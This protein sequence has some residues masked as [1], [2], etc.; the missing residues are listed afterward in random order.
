MQT[1]ILW[2]IKIIIILNDSTQGCP[3]QSSKCMAQVHKLRVLIP[4]KIWD[5]RG[6][7]RGPKGNGDGWSA[8]SYTGRM[9]SSDEG[10]G[11]KNRWPNWV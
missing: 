4:V 2:L 11:L 9:L 3:S 5:W 7:S 1:K 8:W 10:L 6:R